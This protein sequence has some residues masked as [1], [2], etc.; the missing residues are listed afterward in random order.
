MQPGDLV[1][2]RDTEYRYVVQ[3]YPAHEQFCVPVVSIADEGTGTD[4]RLVFADDVSPAE[5]APEAGG[6]L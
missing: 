2:L 6:E 4:V 5:G 1:T 3:P